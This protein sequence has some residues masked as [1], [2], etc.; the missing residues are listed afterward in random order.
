[1]IILLMSFAIN[2]EGQVNSKCDLF[3][4][5]KLTYFN[6][7][8]EKLEVNK[9][10]ECNCGKMINTIFSKA[11][12]LESIGKSENCLYLIMNFNLNIPS[13]DEAKVFMNQITI[14]YDLR[15]YNLVNNLLTK[16][17]EVALND[18]QY[19]L[20]NYIDA[21]VSSKQ[22]RFH[23]S[24]LII[25]KLKEDENI[26]PRR[27]KDLVVLESINLDY[28]GKPQ[29]SK[30]LLLKALDENEIDLSYELWFR[31]AN[32]YLS[33]NLLIESKDI[34]LS[35]LKKKNDKNS[36]LTNFNIGSIYI[37]ITQCYAKL[38]NDSI[39]MYSDS[40][41]YYKS[42]VI[43]KEISPF[44]ATI[45]QNLAE[46]YLHTNQLEKA[47]IQIDSAILHETYH[48]I[49][50][51]SLFELDPDQLYEK[52][53][54]I[55]YLKI[56]IDICEK[57]SPSET[58][59]YYLFLDK[60]IQHLKQDCFYDQTV[61]FHQQNFTELY[62]KAFLYFL[63][64]NDLTQA[65]NFAQKTKNTLLLDKVAQNEF[66]QILPDSISGKIS[67]LER[68]KEHLTDMLNDNI[69]NRDSVLQALNKIFSDLEEMKSRIELEYPQYENRIKSY[70]SIDVN[71]IQKLLREDEC[72][73]DY[74]IS[75]STIH[76]FAIDRK[77][78]NYFSESFD[79]S[80]LKLLDQ[81]KSDISKVP[82]LSTFDPQ[83]YI[84]WKKQFIP[85]TN[86][87]LPSYSDDYNV[88][89]VVPHRFIHG[90]PFGALPKEN[91][92]FLIANHAFATHAS[93]ALF[94]ISRGQDD[95]NHSS[96]LQIIYPEFPQNDDLFL[97]YAEQE[98]VGILQSAGRKN[99]ELIN[100]V[101]QFDNL[102]TDNNLHFLTHAFVTENL[103]ESYLVTCS[104]GE[105]KIKYADIITKY[106]P[107][108]SIAISACESAKGKLIE[109]EGVLSLARGFIQS[110]AQSI[111]AT[112]WKID[113][114]TSSILMSNYYK[115]LNDGNSKEKSLQKAKIEYLESSSY[116]E[117]HPYFWAGYQLL[118]TGK[119]SITIFSNKMKLLFGL[120]SFGAILFLVAFVYKSR[121][122]RAS[123]AAA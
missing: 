7:F 112:N 17:N 106:S 41:R 23:Y 87:L 79:S 75:D 53:S 22:G 107:R 98:I 48:L 86:T 90:I 60:V 66:Y 29:Q 64:Q 62:I 91:G 114:F 85:L 94:T 83:E 102:K 32:S 65:I 119:K 36:F 117:S 49:G 11:K 21:L 4:K 67:I 101:S 16:R 25:Q 69:N 1:M 47:N 3:E 19:L 72:I 24:N 38:K 116:Y 52:L 80:F 34:Y 54:I 50:N 39:F 97:A 99:V 115:L 93:L 110:G 42:K 56:K 63:K 76:I 96:K 120:I 81:F 57:Y 14:L 30:S 10:E 89:H 12:Q 108:E 27:L 111:L 55:E 59:K 61:L 74:T 78:I 15:Y 26:R 84:E 43:E 51:R 70:S 122:D 82:K 6:K 13:C 103:S 20:T 121:I 37:N 73:L 2:I 40:A 9:P 109:G 100:C 33:Q 71:S 88:I 104:E 45:N 68:R 8:K 58:G 35:L 18:G 92:D 5:Y 28:L 46:Y 118:G 77:G 113:D 44:L 95:F 123:K 105:G 31:L